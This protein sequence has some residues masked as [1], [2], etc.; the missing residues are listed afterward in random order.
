MDQQAGRGQVTIVQQP[1]ADNDFRLIVDFDDTAVGGADQYTIILHGVDFSLTGFSQLVDLVQTGSTWRYRDDG[2][3]Q[4]TAWQ[5]IDFD[6]SSWA[7]GPAQLGYG[8]G[9]EATVVSYGPNISFK[10]VTTYFRQAFTIANPAAYPTL[11][12]R[13]LRD[14]GGVVY[15]NGVEV[16]RSRIAGVLLDNCITLGQ[17]PPSEGDPVANN[18]IRTYPYA[19][20]GP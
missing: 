4:G 18:D 17:N 10:Y 1:S 11:T 7:A 16:M 15:L 12:V 14:D 5:A 2:S 9:D 6:D 13:L 8:D 20:R 3:D 19:D